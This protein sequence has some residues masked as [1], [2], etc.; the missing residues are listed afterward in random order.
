MQNIAR[1]CE[2]VLDFRINVQYIVYMSMT[3][4][5]RLRK[6]IN[7]KGIKQSWVARRAE[8]PTSTLQAMLDDRSSPN[9][10]NVK[11]VAVALGLSVDYLLG[12]SK[13]EQAS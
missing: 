4:G 3:L 2:I 13:D 9:V 12:L 8:L 6:H 7:G 1:T 5:Q 11:R 10:D